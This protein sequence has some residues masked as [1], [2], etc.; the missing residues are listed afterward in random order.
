VGIVPEKD[1]NNETYGANP[2]GSGPYKLKQWD[3]GQQ[4]IFEYND[5]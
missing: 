2:V 3:K 5:Q 1:Y 4:A